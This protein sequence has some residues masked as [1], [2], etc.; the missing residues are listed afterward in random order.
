M[1]EQFVVTGGAQGVL[2]HYLL[3]GLQV[4]NDYR[5]PGA[6]LRDCYGSVSI[7]RI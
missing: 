3:P 6:L 7:H 5:H 4:V 1:T 2:T